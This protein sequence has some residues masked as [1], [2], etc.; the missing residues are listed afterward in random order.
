MLSM[1]KGLRVFPASFSELRSFWSIPLRLKCKN[2]HPCL[3]WIKEGTG[4]VKFLCIHVRIYLCT[5]LPV[6][7]KVKM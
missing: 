1:E 5:L 2:K 6:S 3:L 4:F 7:I